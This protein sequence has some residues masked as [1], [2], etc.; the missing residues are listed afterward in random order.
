M[1]WGFAITVKTSADSSDPAGLV[2]LTLPE[3]TP[4]GT[5]SRNNASET[6]V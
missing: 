1:T 2:T 3:A 5:V 6:T 4:P